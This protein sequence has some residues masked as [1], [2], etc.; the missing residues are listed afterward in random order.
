M[1]VVDGNRALRLLSDGLFHSMDE[2]EGVLQVSAKDITQWCAELNVV[3]YSLM[4]GREGVRWEAPFELLSEEGIWEGL[5]DISKSWLT[6]IEIRAATGSTNDDARALVMKSMRGCLV[7]AEAQRKGRGQ[8]G[9]EWCSTPGAGI[10]MSLAWSR[11]GGMAYP[12]SMSL[13]AGIA[14]AKAL[15]NIG[16][17]RVGVKWPNDIYLEGRKLGGVLIELFHTAKG[18]VE[19][20]VGVG[21]NVAGGDDLAGVGQPYAWVREVLPLIER[22]ALVL[23]I[24]NEISPVLGADEEGGYGYIEREW[25]AFDIA[26]G[27]CVEVIGGRGKKEGVGMGLAPDYSYVVESAEGLL[28][29]DGGL[30]RMRL[31]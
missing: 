27:E 28:F 29:V 21:I 15:R 5:S 13:V 6:D 30:T 7:L 11:C 2:L 8:R 4:L 9:R 26:R 19:L 24:V 17:K 14:V 25:E 1:K 10:Y 23:A 20:V 12:R 18:A 3:G 22:E 16:V 31:L